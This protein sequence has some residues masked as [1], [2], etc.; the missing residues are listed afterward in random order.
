M[1]AILV[2]LAALVLAASVS[3]AA[4]VTPADGYIYSAQTLG[5]ITQSCVAAAPGGNFVALGPGFTAGGQSIVFVSES[6]SEQTVAAGFNSVA[7]CAYDL[8]ADVLYV[9]DNSLEVVG[10]VTGDTVYAI[11]MAT[12]RTD[13][14]SAAA[15]EL[16][17]AGTLGSAAS[18]AVGPNGELYVSDAAGAG[19]GAVHRIT[20]AGLESFI[21]SGFDYTAGLAFTADGDL[22][23][24]ETTASFSVLVS[25]YDSGGNKIGDLSG[26]GWAHGSYDL[27]RDRDGSLLVTGAW[28]GDV[29]R[30]AGDGG[31]SAFAGGLTYATGIHADAFTGRV[32][33]LSSTFSGVEED[34]SIHRFTPVDRLVAGRGSSRTECTNEIYG[35][36]LAARRDGARAKHAICRDGDACDGDGVAIDCCLFPVGFCLSIDAARLADCTPAGVSAFSVKSRPGT[37]WFEETVTRVAADLP[38]TSAACYF[39]D[40][41]TVPLKVKAAGKRPGKA[42]LK[43]KAADNGDRRRKDR[44]SVKFMC[45][46][47]D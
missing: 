20:A 8:A 34:K 16:L 38:L 36:E 11:E 28:G 17:P 33:I 15:S 39:S 9:T 45:L 14:A 27:A 5:D 2:A 40:G 10:A 12:V 42:R 31:T 3:P 44:D 30:I 25:I 29:V 26:P 18:V 13:T 7:D 1:R 4:A 6:G 46:P 41:L 22:A 37:G 21:P 43:V 24:A 32:S 47:A 19:A 23:V 35:I